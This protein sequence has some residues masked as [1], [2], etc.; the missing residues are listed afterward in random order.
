MMNPIKGCADCIGSKSPS[1]WGKLVLAY[2]T[3]YAF[4]TVWMFIHLYGLQYNA[5]DTAS[6]VSREGFVN[7]EIKYTYIGEP[8]Y[9]GFLDGVATTANKADDNMKLSPEP[10]TES[11]TRLTDVTVT[12]P[13]CGTDLSSCYIN[14][15]LR[16]NNHFSLVE[17]GAHIQIQCTHPDLTFFD[18]TDPW[19]SN[20]TAP[21]HAT[22]GEIAINWG[23]GAKFPHIVQF[24]V[25]PTNAVTDADQSFSVDNCKLSTPLESPPFES[26]LDQKYTFKK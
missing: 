15:Q 25:R 7:G 21:C 18:C 2:T 3:F 23:E 26:Y 6:Q 11:K 22:Q 4:V 8:I 1:D 17:L 13:T 5:P 9:N 19:N 20:E 10:W 14:Q 24:K 16:L 12:D